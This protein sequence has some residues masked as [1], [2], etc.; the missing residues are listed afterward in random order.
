MTETDTAI[1]AMWDARMSTA[2]IAAV[3][4]MTE[5][6]VDRRLNRLREARREA[7]APVI[8][9]LPITPQETAFLETKSEIEAQIAAAFGARPAAALAPRPRHLYRPV[10]DQVLRYARWFV[11]ASWS[12]REV[13]WLFGVEPEDLAEALSV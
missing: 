13:A 8:E 2:S 9:P 3:M 12:V 11:A 6:A 1:L 4:S 10:R 5:A 7:A